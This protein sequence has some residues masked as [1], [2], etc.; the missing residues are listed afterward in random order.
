MTAEC[1][2]CGS[3]VSSRFHRVFCDNDGVLHGCHNCVGNASSKHPDKIEE[4][5]GRSL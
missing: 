2:N 3:A 4:E 1:D 5:R